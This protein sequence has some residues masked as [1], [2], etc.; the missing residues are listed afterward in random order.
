[1]KEELLMR[2]KLPMIER[3]SL[4]SAIVALGYRKTGNKFSV[5]FNGSKGYLSNIEISCEG[6]QKED[7]RIFV[8]S[9]RNKNGSLQSKMINVFYS[10]QNGIRI[11]LGQDDPR[12][13]RREEV[14]GLHKYAIPDDDLPF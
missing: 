5:R 2:F 8:D 14:K 4:V 3:L 13:I 9:L 10:E 12:V 7:N 6:C 1:M 11:S